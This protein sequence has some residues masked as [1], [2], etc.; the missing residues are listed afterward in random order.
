MSK[1][2]Q[3]LL[4]QETKETLIKVG[5]GLVLISVISK[6][7]GDFVFGQGGPVDLVPENEIDY[8]ATQNRKFITNSPNVG[9]YVLIKDPWKP[10]NLAHDL[11]TSMEGINPPGTWGESDRSRA[12]SEVARLGIDRA[13]W[14]HNYWLQNIDKDDT[15]YRW[16]DGEYWSIMRNRPEDIAYENA[17]SMLKRAGVGF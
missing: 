5:V 11:Y 10:N 2:E 3:P 8:E 14:L 1:S 13:R 15:I 6:K 9:D 12:W 4:S 17:L 7:I 16:I